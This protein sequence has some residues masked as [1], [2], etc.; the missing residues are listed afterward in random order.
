MLHATEHALDLER[1]TRARFEGW[2]RY[3]NGY[4]AHGANLD[5]PPPEEPA[6]PAHS[7]EKPRE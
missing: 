1:A 7:T 6:E 2:A 5:G 3:L 4:F